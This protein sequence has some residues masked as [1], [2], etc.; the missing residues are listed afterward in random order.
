MIA[1]ARQT[2]RVVAAGAA[3]DIRHAERT[4][5]ILRGL[6]ADEE[7]VTAGLLH[8]IAKPAGTRLWHRIAGVLLDR[9]A[10]R[11]RRELA[12]GDSTFARYLDHA[13]IGAAEAR[14]RG[15]SDRVVFLIA[16]HHSPARS[17]DARLL[18]R[19]DREALP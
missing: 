17:E 15:A 8:D 14:R 9:V 1:R 19:A 3:A 5:A 10:P 2:M 7:L 18:A 4:A 11:V 6:G 13:R 16:G 12:R